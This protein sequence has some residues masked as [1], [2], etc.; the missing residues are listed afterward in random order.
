MSTI[1]TLFLL[2]IFIMTLYAICKQGI[3]WKA[4]QEMKKKKNK[5]KSTYSSSLVADFFVLRFS[6][7][8]V[9]SVSV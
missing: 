8:S 7:I 2:S 9:F 6:G 4:L 5:E 1:Y 3:L